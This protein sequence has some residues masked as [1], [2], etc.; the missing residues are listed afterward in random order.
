MRRSQLLAQQALQALRAEQDADKVT[1]QQQIAYAR[2]VLS[3]LDEGLIKELQVISDEAADRSSHTRAIFN[4]LMENERKRISD[5]QR[6]L[7]GLSAEGDVVTV[8]LQGDAGDTKAI[9]GSASTD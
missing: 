7:D 8:A 9:E 5:L 3:T 1:F 6:A 4:E 2:A